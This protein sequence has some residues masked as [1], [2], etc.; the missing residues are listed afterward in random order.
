MLEGTEGTEGTNGGEEGGDRGWSCIY[1]GGRLALFTPEL[2]PDCP[3]FP[4]GAIG[5]RRCDHCGAVFASENDP[6]VKAGVDSAWRW[7]HRGDAAKEIERSLDTLRDEMGLD[8][9]RFARILGDYTRSRASRGGADSRSTDLVLRGPE[10]SRAPANG[11]G[12]A[13]EVPRDF[14]PRSEGCAENCPIKATDGLEICCDNSRSCCFFCLDEG[15]PVKREFSRTIAAAM[16][17]PDDGLGA[18][19]EGEEEGYGSGLRPDDVL[20]RLELEEG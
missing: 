1:C 11:A 6:A 5:W 15:C 18:E 12:E 17:E 13:G 20:D 14:D 3:E 9:E 7:F 2:P 4:D 8:E 10:G 19:D 16:D